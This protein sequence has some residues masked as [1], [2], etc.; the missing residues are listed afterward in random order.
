MTK[1]TAQKLE[2]RMYELVGL[3][4]CYKG[5]R[6]ELINRKRAALSELRA[7]IEANNHFLTNPEGIPRDYPISGVYRFSKAA[8]YC[9]SMLKQDN[10]NGKL[11]RSLSIVE[12]FL[13]NGTTQEGEYHPFKAKDY[14]FGFTPEITREL[15]RLHPKLAR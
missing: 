3:G 1:T 8:E 7:R 14:E 9:K 6:I 15:T 10:T 12:R 2:R 13:N 11:R 4:D 5:R